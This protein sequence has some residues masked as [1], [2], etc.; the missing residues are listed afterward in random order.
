MNLCIIKILALFQLSLIF[1][2]T[3]IKATPLIAVRE[4]ENCAG[5][6]NGG[7][8]QRPFIWRRCTLDCQGC[9]IDPSGA[10]A[11]NQWGEYYSKDQLNMVELYEA[12]DPL[13]DESFADIHYD[14]RVIN[15]SD[16]T[17]GSFSPM[18]SEYT[19]R[20][21]PLIRWIHATYSAMFLGRTDDKTFRFGPNKRFFREKYSIMVDALPM[22]LYLKY[23]RGTP[24]YGQ[25][26]PNHSAWIRERVGLDQFA[27]SDAFTI[28]GTLNVPFVHLS[29]LE[30]DPYAEAEDRQKGT[31]TH[32]GMRGVSF[33]WNV[34][35]STWNTE[36]K[37][38]KISMSAIG[39]GAHVFNVLFMGERNF[40]KVT[41]KSNSTSTVTGFDHPGHY[42]HPSSTIS[43]YTL[44]WTGMKGLMVGLVEENMETETFSSDRRS[45]FVDIHPIPSVQL[46]FWR[47]HE[48]GAKN[49]WD[50]LAVFHVYGDF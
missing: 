7:R 43:E 45:Y 29:M 20:L 40:R 39:G 15:R 12:V 8:S 17:G 24:M 2:P 4:T 48:S 47:R 33:G 14:G 21:R 6:H 41:E 49:V 11:R 32:F 28:G 37:K 25:R 30:G 22:N 10:G 27:T 5:C 50:T 9:H 18:A 34:H 23:G 46:E 38:S 35:G 1:A 16:S 19:F 3:T 36:S 42:S 26:R 31:S 13:K 44:A